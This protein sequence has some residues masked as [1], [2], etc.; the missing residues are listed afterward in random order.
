[1][2][3]RF[4]AVLLVSVPLVAVAQ[5]ADLPNLVCAE[6]DTGS[7]LPR[8]RALGPCLAWSHVSES[9]GRSTVNALA[10]DPT[11]HLV[12]ASGV[13]DASVTVTALRATDGMPV[14]ESILN[15]PDWQQGN[16]FFL[17]TSSTG[18]SVYAAGYAVLSGD[19]WEGFLASLDPASGAERWRA[20]LERPDAVDQ[21]LFVA[22]STDGTIL[23]ALARSS[24]WDEDAVVQ[25]LEAATGAVLWEERSTN[26]SAGRLV[27]SPDGSRLYTTGYT[28]TP[29]ADL[30]GFSPN[31]DL[32]VSAYAA[33]DGAVLWR[34]RYDG[35]GHDMDAGDDIGLS[36]D[37]SAL[38][39]AGTTTGDGTGFDMS[40]AS[41]DAVT[42]ALNW[43]RSEDT[44]ALFD[45]VVAP[46]GSKAYLTSTVQGPEHGTF[47]QTSAY[48]TADGNRL[49]TSRYGD[50]DVDLDFAQGL[51]LAP[52]GEHVYV[53]GMAEAGTCGGWPMF[54]FLMVAYE[55]STGGE[56]WTGT[57]DG[58]A[59]FEDEVRDVAMGP[60]GDL[61]FQGGM[62]LEESFCDVTDVEGAVVAWAME[63]A[64]L[65]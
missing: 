15:G 26:R 17:G 60:G 24:A 28:C 52:D 22:P 29:G 25:A 47:V 14:W 35:P 48:S 55:A 49:W 21:Y 37:G 62:T 34:S 56:V 61:V 64:P 18:D 4:A 6:A 50:L 8:L 23:Y 30:C 2:L 27:V 3:Q 9:D 13:R 39:V 51:A 31:M 19:E 38:I 43:I 59:H 1:M 46:D 53:S 63:P 57:W 36:A 65:A 20:R 5:A 10:A 33:E 54:D 32:E 44:Q 40:V 42:G 12:Y 16:V 41:F 58:P 7:F 11:G 45:A